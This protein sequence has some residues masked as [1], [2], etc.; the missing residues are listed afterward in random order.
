[1]ARRVVTVKPSEK[2]A[3][4]LKMKLAAMSGKTP[5]PAVVKIANAQPR[6][7]GS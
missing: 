4:Q 2:A 5:S 1:M 6:A 3:A 7:T